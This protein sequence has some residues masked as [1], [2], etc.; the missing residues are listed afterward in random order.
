MA[1]SAARS[2]SARLAAGLARAL[3]AVAALLGAVWLYARVQSPVAYYGTVYPNR[4]EAARFAGLGT[5]GRPAS[6]EPRGRVTALFFGFLN[7]PNVCPLTLAYLEK[8]RASLPSALRDDFQIAFVTLDPD[9]DTP[10][11][12]GTYVRYFG[13]EIEGYFVEEPRLAAVARSYGVEY[14][15]VAARGAS[16]YQ[17]NH[18]PGTYLIDREGRLRLV[19]DYTQL[20]QVERVTRDLTLVLRE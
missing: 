18:T 6:F 14:A 15:K 5:D 19:W 11:K 10:D 4:P 7:C 2:R 20:P 8:A 9:R 17:V 3:V 1:T 16:G 12:I 13:R